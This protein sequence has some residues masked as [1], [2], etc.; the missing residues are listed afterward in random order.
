MLTVRLGQKPLFPQLVA[1]F[2]SLGENLVGRDINLGE[3]E[4]ST[5]QEIVKII[6]LGLAW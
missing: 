1:R 5:S 6:R 3:D 2:S 4:T